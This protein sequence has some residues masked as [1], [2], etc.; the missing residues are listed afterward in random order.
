MKKILIIDAHPNNESYC[1]SLST[2]YE[3][4]ATNSGHEVKKLAFRE[5]KFDLNLHEGYKNL[6]PLESD[7][8][9]AQ[10]MISWCNHLVIVYPN[11]WSSMPALLKGFFDRCFLPGFAF[12]YQKDNP[13][14]EKLLSEKSARIIVTSDSPHWYNKII[15]LN[16]PIRIVKN[17][18]LKFNGFNPVRVTPLGGVR[19]STEKKRTKWNKKIKSLGEKGL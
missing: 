6:P 7:L 16:S 13:L 19:S 14:W 2:L 18:I 17:R 4:Q 12:Q 1:S 10:D 9:L 5:M 11:W 3:E 8:I 15:H